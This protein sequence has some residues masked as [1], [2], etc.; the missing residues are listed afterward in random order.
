MNEVKDEKVDEVIKKLFKESGNNILTPGGEDPLK[1]LKNVSS[2]LEEGMMEL[3][4]HIMLVGEGL[5]I[6]RLQ[7]FMLTKILVDKEIITEEEVNKRWNTDVVEEMKR[8]KEKIQKK[9]EEQY[10][11]VINEKEKDE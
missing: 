1:D 11:D 10:Q 2:H 6:A 4:N 9:I 7:N 8:Q 3:Y 5:D